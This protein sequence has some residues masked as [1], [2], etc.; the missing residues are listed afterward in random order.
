METRPPIVPAGAV[1]SGDSPSICTR[2][3]RVSTPGQRGP[4]IRASIRDETPYD[5]KNGD[6][7]MM[8][9][10]GP[11]GVVDSTTKRHEE[12]AT[13]KKATACTREEDVHGLYLAI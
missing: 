4:F 11:Y 3:L 9:V 8:G 10:A 1:I 2:M 13:R 7:Y 6:D 12:Y 5:I